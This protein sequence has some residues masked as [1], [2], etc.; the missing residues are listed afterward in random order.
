VIPGASGRE[1]QPPGS[2][3]DIVDSETAMRIG[4]GRVRPR[5]AEN[6]APNGQPRRPLRRSGLDG[7]R[8]TNLWR[9][10]PFA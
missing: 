3:I 6:D 8:I 10:Q 4:E 7:S 5:R 2:D 9:P 1:D